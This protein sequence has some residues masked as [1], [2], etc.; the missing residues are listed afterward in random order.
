MRLADDKEQERL[1][2]VKERLLPAIRSELEAENATAVE[3]LCLMAHTTG[4]LLAM[5]DQRTVTASQA[6]SWVEN[7]IEAG[8]REAVEQLLDAGAGTA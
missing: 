4:M 7:N 8:N 5:Q 3:L 2:G 6:L 1:G